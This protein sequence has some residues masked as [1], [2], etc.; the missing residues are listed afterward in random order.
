MKAL[1]ICNPY[2]NLIFLPRDDR[3]AK[4]IEN[5]SWNS[6][7]YRGPLVIHAGKSRAWLTDEYGDVGELHYGALI[8]IVD[9]ID[10]VPKRDLAKAYPHLADHRHAEG[11]LC[12]ILDYPRRFAEPIPWSG[13]QGFWN[14]PDEVIAAAKKIP[15]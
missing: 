4:P 6:C 5:R 14:V 2:P 13:A 12:L 7:S 8:G 11:P 15:V 10:A 9:L 1:T 3:R